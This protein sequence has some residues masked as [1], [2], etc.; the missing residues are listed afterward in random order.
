MRIG[1]GSGSG[2]FLTGRRG[3][4]LGRGSGSVPIPVRGAHRAAVG[5]LVA[6]RGAKWG[7]VGRLPE[8]AGP[9]AKPHRRGCEGVGVG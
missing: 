1:V 7:E 8:N 2:Q 6:L 5:G 3:S 9:V 4:W